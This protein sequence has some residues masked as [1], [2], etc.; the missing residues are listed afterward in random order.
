M[1]NDKNNGFTLLELIVTLAILALLVTALVTILDQTNFQVAYLS[2]ELSRRSSVAYSLDQLM[3]DIVSHGRE[4]LDIQIK[5]NDS[6]KTCWL[7]IT[8]KTFESKKRGNTI[9]QIDWVAIPRED[10]DDL[11]L[12]RREIVGGDNDGGSFIP[13]CGQLHSFEVR[14]LNGEGMETSTVEVTGVI[15][16]EAKMYRQNDK[17]EE[18]VLTFRR[19]FALQRFEK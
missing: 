18:G 3:D 9:R 7:T 4:N 1:K 2:E 13:Q 17:D 8:M 16:V 15:E 10:E 12:F 6:R 14:L 19:T 5:R 11:V